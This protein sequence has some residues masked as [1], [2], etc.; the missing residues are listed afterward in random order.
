M[1]TKKTITEILR[2][3]YHKKLHTKLTLEY[4]P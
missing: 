1:T 2:S 3:L 4:S